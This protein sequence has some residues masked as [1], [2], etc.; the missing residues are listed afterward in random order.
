MEYGI[1]HIYMVLPSP[2]RVFKIKILVLTELSPIMII[3]VSADDFFQSQMSSSLIHFVLLLR[4][5]FEQKDT[6]RAIMA[7]SSYRPQSYHRAIDT[8]RSQVSLHIR[9]W[10]GQHQ[11]AGASIETF[12]QLNMKI[13]CGVFSTLIQSIL[14][15]RTISDLLKTIF[16]LIPDN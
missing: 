8:K 3:E 12:K 4:T 13:F 1:F 11:Q 10:G 16:Q 2:V 15:F 5:S 6:G 7:A 9:M 14:F